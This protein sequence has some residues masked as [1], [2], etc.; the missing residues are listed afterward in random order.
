[1]A[2]CVK[3]RTYEKG[4]ERGMKTDD[5]DDISDYVTYR[6]DYDDNESDYVSVLFRDWHYET[7]RR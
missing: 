7:Y 4:T 3:I 2:A 1:M 6:F 5:L